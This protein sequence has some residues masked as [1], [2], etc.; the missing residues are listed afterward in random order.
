M[1]ATDP[2]ADEMT[3]HD[4]MTMWFSR[5]QWDLSVMLYITRYGAGDDV[6]KFRDADEGVK[7]KLRLA[8]EELLA[9]LIV[10]LADE[11]ARGADLYCAAAI[12]EHARRILKA[13]A[14]HRG[15]YL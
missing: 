15:A 2:E 11:F 8:G 9:L 14:Q 13:W 12:Q 5:M 1:S 7:L 10:D 3:S 6:P 4:R